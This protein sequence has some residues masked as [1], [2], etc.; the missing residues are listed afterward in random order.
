ML[1]EAYDVFPAEMF[2][3]SDVQGY[4]IENFAR[5]DEDDDEEDEEDECDDDDD[6]DDEDEDE[7]EELE[8]ELD[9]LRELDDD[10]DR[11]EDEDVFSV[12]LTKDAFES[13]WLV[14]VLE[15]DEEELLDELLELLDELE[16]LL[17]E[18]AE[19][20][21][22]QSVNI[23]TSMAAEELRCC[24]HVVAPLS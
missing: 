11:E 23:C 18:D 13:C 2:G 15:D 6:D 5:E 8:E 17:D 14:A 10:D 22:G 1:G 9:E 21:V 12:E 4:V 7:D 24:T 16:L 3:A 20:F 19:A